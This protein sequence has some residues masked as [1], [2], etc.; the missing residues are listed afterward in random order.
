MSQYTD[1]NEPKRLHPLT[2]LYKGIMNA[3]ALIIPLYFAISKGHTDE[4]FYIFIMIFIFFFTLPSIILNYYFFKFQITNNELV[5]Y[6]GI[7]AK[8]Q[9]NIPV[10]R[11]QNINMEQNFLQRMLGITKVQIETAGEATAEG[12]LEYVSK[13]DAAKIANTIRQFQDNYNVVTNNGSVAE[14]LKNNIDVRK[15]IIDNNE[16]S[17]Q[18]LFSMSNFKVIQYGMLRFRP[19]ALVFGAWIFSMLQQ[20]FPMESISEKLIGSN[21]EYVEKLNTAELLYYGVIA[22]MLIIF[23]SW[24]L[25]II[26]TFNKYY[27]FKLT[28]DSNKFI[29]NYGLFTKKQVTIPLKKLQS[30][31]ITTNPIKKLINYYSLGLQTAGMG[32]SPSQNV[33]AIPFASIN[34]VKNLAQNIRE[35][36]FPEAFI[37]V[38]KKTIQRA[39]VKYFLYFI[40]IVAGLYFVSNNA[41]WLLVL[42]PV[43]IWSAIL[44]WQYRGYS[45]EDELIFVK[46]GFWF[47]KVSIV[48]IEKIQTL[49]IKESFFQRRLGLATLHIDTAASFLMN[50]C[51][52]IDID[53]ED[54]QLISEKLMGA[55]KNHKIK[56]LN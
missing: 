24:L 9:K 52:I 11:I 12:V 19:I 16:N 43:I 3:P 42:I 29:T 41:L 13:H 2:L 17:A 23:S 32:A 40:P 20:F 46:Q 49:I 1:Y 7:I 30:I 36:L 45:I 22:V 35:F 6:S 31:V 25:D 10:R 26:L 37:K 14:S 51:S 33:V 54:A 4:L 28:K 38:S 27:G 50:D 5:I 44:K 55:F 53:T 56:K 21:F 48:P 18:E 34:E 15:N 8:K 39:L 47:Q